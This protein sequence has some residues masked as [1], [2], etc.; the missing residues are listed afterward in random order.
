MNLTMLAMNGLPPYTATSLAFN[1]TIGAEGC[2]SR[3]SLGH[4]Y[5]CG[6]P[7]KNNNRK[8]TCR[9]RSE[10]MNCHLCKWSRSTHKL[11][12]WQRMLINPD[13]AQSACTEQSTGSG[14]KS[15]ASSIGDGSYFSGDFVIP[16]L[17]A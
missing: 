15:S 6:P 16:R 8:R 7:C 9:I 3:G 13:T 4:P 17:T 5:F 2:P 11:N 14:Q 10:C 1:P 12:G